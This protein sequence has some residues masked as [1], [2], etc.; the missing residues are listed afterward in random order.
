[1]STLEEKGI[2]KFIRKDIKEAT[3]LPATLKKLTSVLK[4]NKL[5]IT[6]DYMIVQ[7][8]LMHMATFVNFSKLITLC[9][10]YGFKKEAKIFD[11]AC[12]KIDDIIAKNLDFLELT[13]TVVGHLHDQFEAVFSTHNG[14]AKYLLFSESIKNIGKTNME[15]KTLIKKWDKLILF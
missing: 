3:L 1:M 15:F 13:G 4:K 6:D 12:N 7:L 9:N 2:L 10:A 8:G 5:K 11:N 14:N